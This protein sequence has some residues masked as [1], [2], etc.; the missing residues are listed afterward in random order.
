MKVITNQIRSWSVYDGLSKRNK[1]LSPGGNTECTRNQLNSKHS[2]SSRYYSPAQRLSDYFKSEVLI[3]NVRQVL[4]KQNFQWTW[5]TNPQSLRQEKWWYLS[6]LLKPCLFKKWK[7]NWCTV[8]A[9]KSKYK[10][11]LFN[12]NKKSEKAWLSS[13]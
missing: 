7:K 2:D 12:E 10:Q 3:A 13:M 8:F 4:C 5:A 11:L 1:I 9:I 6:T